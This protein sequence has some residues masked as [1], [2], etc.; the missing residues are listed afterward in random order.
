MNENIKTENPKVYNRCKFTVSEDKLMVFMSCSFESTAEQDLL[1]EDIYSKISRMGIS[2]NLDEPELITAIEKARNNGEGVTDLLIIKGISPV[3]PQDGK[4][5]WMKDY[6]AEGYYVD[7]DTKAIDYRQKAELL[8]VTEGESLVKVYQEIS[9]ENGCDVYGKLIRVQSPKKVNVRAG[10]NV[11]WDSDEGVY[12]AKCSG[13]LSFKSNL[14]E[15]LDLYSIFGDVGLET[16]NIKHNGDVQIKG[17][18]ISNFIVEAT[19]NIEIGGVVGASNIICGGDLI[20]KGGINGNI[21]NKI[22]VKGNVYS[23]YCN[24]ALIECDG[25][26]H[27]KVGI[28]HSHFYCS[29]KAIC[30]GVVM[31]SVITAAKGISVAEAGSKNNTDTTLV[32]GV[33]YK[34]M[35][36]IKKLSEDRENAK[37]D[38]IVHEINRK[39]IA[40]I[41]NILNDKQKAV[42]DEINSDIVETKK[43]IDELLEEEK[44]NRRLINSIRDTEIE[45]IDTVYTETILRVQDSL[46]RVSNT[47]KGPLVASID[48]TTGKIGLCSKSDEKIK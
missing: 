31:G 34:L 11:A 23:K 14:I 2:N 12:K 17:E 7:P 15:V 8:T 25:D 40:T 47:L 6:F 38:L 43:N 21:E 32:S 5:E 35:N 16:G 36:L 29:G 27:I 28:H 22:I 9:G 19:G 18:V 13:R 26:I 37:K 10:Q 42:L 1:L 4:L 33:D 45:I 30:D 20:V 46:F 39:K 48:N 24:N 41:G 44:R 3:M